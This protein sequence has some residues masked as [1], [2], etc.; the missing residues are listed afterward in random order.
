MKLWLI[1]QNTNNGYDTYDASVVAAKTEEEA[2]YI[3]PSGATNWDGKMTIY[4]S[5]VASKDVQVEYLGETD[6]DISGVVLASFN[7]G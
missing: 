3:H 7:A 6:R 1:S 4:N 5:W 2:R